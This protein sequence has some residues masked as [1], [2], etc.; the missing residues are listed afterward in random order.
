[1]SEKRDFDFCPRCGALM[2]N[3]VCQ[4]CGRGMPRPPQMTDGYYTQNPPNQTQMQQG[5]P[6]MQYGSGVSGGPGTGPVYIHA[7]PA[8]RKNHTAVIVIGVSLTVILIVGLLTA[9]IV[10]LANSARN[11]VNN[12]R[13]RSGRDS[14]DEYYD[15]Y[16]GGYDDEYDYGYYEPDENDPYYEEIV[17]WTRT[18]LDY[19]IQWAVESV[20]PD[21]GSD[22]CTYYTTYPILD[23][24]GFEEF[25]A[26]N[27]K[28]RQKAVSYRDSYKD[29][30]G[31]VSTF[32]YV[33]M[34]DEEKIS[35]VFKH[36]FYKED[37]V[38]VRLDACTFWIDSKEEAAPEEMTELD[39]DLAMRFQSQDKIQ[40]DG[41]EYVQNLTG[42][43][44]LEILKDPKQAV[45]F[46][47][48]VGLEVGLNYESGWVTVTLKEQAL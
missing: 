41:V 37:V 29:Y 43:E 3:G 10:S 25:D 8:K 27:E 45:F 13:D 39:L 1:M 47:T 12:G 26:V 42:E 38:E 16:Y 48:P 4:S 24:E 5:N 18:D 34:M 22:D 46:Y 14:Y 19:G 9:L 40:N 17:D 23:R 6:G 44:L 31:G 11:S 7:A 30:E 15:D 35:V 28:I 33:T 2:Q 36:N 20:D 32:G 21:D